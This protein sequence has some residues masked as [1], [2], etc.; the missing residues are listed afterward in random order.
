M[1]DDKVLIRRM[2][3]GDTD[4]LAE[5]FLKHKDRLLTHASCLLGDNATAEDCLQDVFLKLVRDVVA[6]RVRRNL[7]SYLTSCVLNRARDALRKDGR[8]LRVAT[9][10]VDEMGS[11]GADASALLEGLEEAERVHRAL[12]LLPLEQREVVVLHLQAGETFRHIGALQSVSIN[13]VQS[14]YRYGIQRLRE[15]LTEEEEK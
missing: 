13:T 8:E 2:R 1:N 15:L 12:V 4:A 3:N 10:R 6:L 11:T 7:G 5:V 14:R 9:D